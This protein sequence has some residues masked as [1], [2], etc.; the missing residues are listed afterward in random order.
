[1]QEFLA[2][3]SDVTTYFG[4]KPFVKSRIDKVR[5][6]YLFIQSQSASKFIRELQTPQCLCVHRFIQ[7][8]PSFF[9]QLRWWKMLLTHWRQ[10]SQIQTSLV[11]WKTLRLMDEHWIAES[12]GENLRLYVVSYLNICKDAFLGFLYTKQEVNIPQQ[13]FSF[14]QY[15]WL[16]SQSDILLQWR[17]HCK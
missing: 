5:K 11:Q 1:M 10:L 13:K 12:I 6:L 8:F 14:S 7:F 2:L 3:N 16:A 17:Q 15:T 9:S 4:R